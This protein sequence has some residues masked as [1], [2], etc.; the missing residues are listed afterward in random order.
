[1]KDLRARRAAHL[2]RGLIK[3]EP[4]C[5]GILMAIRRAYQGARDSVDAPSAG[6]YDP[7]EASDAIREAPGASGEVL[8]V[9]HEVCG[10]S[11]GTFSMKR[12][13]SNVFREV[14]HML[15]EAFDMNCGARD[16]TTEAPNINAVGKSAVFAGLSCDAVGQTAAVA[17]QSRDAVG[18]SAVVAGPS[19]NAVEK[20]A[21]NVGQS[22]DAVGKT[23][24]IAGQSCD[25]V[26]KSAVNGARNL[27]ADGFSAVS[28]VIGSKLR[29][30]TPGDERAQ[31]P[32]NGRGDVPSALDLAVCDC[33]R[34]RFHRR[35]FLRG[36]VVCRGLCD[37]EHSAQFISFG[38]EH[39]NRE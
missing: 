6:I 7:F 10:T 39:G 29:R 15:R 1:V 38:A 13:V 9:T 25:A 22:C 31:P 26:G 11:D 19:R 32:V 8:S 24:V 5:E 23:A 12:Q 33:P 35:G 34:D 14:F 21:V 18:K 27:V 30:L 4:L 2:L 3:V 20:S 37:A 16:M 17:G 36:P 28:R